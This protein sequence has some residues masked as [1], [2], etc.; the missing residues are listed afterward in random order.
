MFGIKRRIEVKTID[1]ILTDPD[2]KTLLAK[3]VKNAPNLERLAI[4]TTQGR[5]DKIETAGFDDDSLNLVLDRMK[6]RII[7]ESG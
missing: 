4:I 5:Y 7:R 3:V 6:N 2:I 1:D